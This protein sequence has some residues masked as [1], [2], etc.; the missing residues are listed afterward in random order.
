MVL[1]LLSDEVI[2]GILHKY[3]RVRKLN[4][5]SNGTRNAFN[6]TIYKTCLR[7]QP[8]FLFDVDVDVDDLFQGLRH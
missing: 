7:T 8:L 2:S 5:S 1:T 3:G 4:L 6:N